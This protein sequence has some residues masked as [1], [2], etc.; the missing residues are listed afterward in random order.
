MRTQPPIHDFSRDDEESIPLRVFPLERKSH[1]DSSVPH[2]HNYY[3]VFLFI[4]GSGSHFIDFE[5]FP[6]HNNSIHFVSPGQVHMV[7]RGIGSY[8]F[9][10]LFSRDFYYTNARQDTLF[11]LPFLN[12]NSRK[13]VIDLNEEQ[14]EPLLQLVKEMENEF[15]GADPHRQELIYSLLNILL[16]RAKRYFSDSRD[17]ATESG[18]G[19]IFRQF[20]VL[21]E[22]SFTTLHSPSAYA[23]KLAV[24]EKYLNQVV[25][26]ISGRTVSEHIAARIS[27]EARR[28]LLHSDLSFKEIAAFLHFEDASYF[29]RFFRKQSGKTPSQFRQESRKEI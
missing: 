21:L 10:I 6:I 22:N 20:R 27:L 16:I 29:S 9:A 28:L 2:R 1:Y 15:N 17:S 12:N 5:N 13:P 18:P 14:F 19:R 3:E 23:E 7:K 11:T 8:G 26:N 4:E 25:K 24:S